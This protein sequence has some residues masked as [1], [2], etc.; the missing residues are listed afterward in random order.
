MKLK[1]IPCPGT[2]PD[3]VFM[4]IFAIEA[5]REMQPPGTLNDA[6]KKSMLLFLLPLPFLS[7]R[8]N[9]KQNI[10]TETNMLNKSA[11]SSFEPDS[12]SS[13]EKVNFYVLK[14][15]NRF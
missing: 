1:K 14:M 7:H 6:F 4:A 9:V 8:K 10:L 15:G 3:A 5:Q 2:Q 12:K 13:F 11:Q